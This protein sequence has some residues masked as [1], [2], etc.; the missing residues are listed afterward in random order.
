MHAEETICACLINDIGVLQRYSAECHA[1]ETAAGHVQCP[2][3]DD[4][5]RLLHRTPRPSLS[6][7]AVGIAVR[8]QA[9]NCAPS[10][11]CCSVTSTRCTP[12]QCCHEEKVRGAPRAPLGSPCCGWAVCSPCTTSY[13]LGTARTR[14][15]VLLTKLEPHLSADRGVAQRL[16]DFCAAS[17]VAHSLQNT[18][19]QAVELPKHTAVHAPRCG[20]ASA[21]RLTAPSLLAGRRGLLTASWRRRS[22]GALIFRSRLTQVLAAL[23]Q[24]P[25][26]KTTADHISNARVSQLLA[27]FCQQ[28]CDLR[29]CKVLQTP[30]AC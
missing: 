5:Q 20:L 29:D 2:I 15:Y 21:A 16:R 23:K 11:Y 10:R 9:C 7:C 12:K 1:A 22:R 3:S 26:R 24:E 6:A 27:Q 13:A 28:P 18:L 8:C 25:H 14:S 19:Q 4:L 17:F 30:Q